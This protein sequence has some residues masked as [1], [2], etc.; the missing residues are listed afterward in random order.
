VGPSPTP[1]RLIALLGGFPDP[2]PLDARVLGVT[3]DGGCRRH[4][5][6]YTTLGDER[7]QAFLLSPVG[8]RG[9]LPGVLAIHQDGGT[10]EALAAEADRFGRFLGTP[11]E[12]AIV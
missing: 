1:E 5:V 11:A 12:I 4:L 7:V 2:P 6:E 3:E 10:R 8:A 9:P